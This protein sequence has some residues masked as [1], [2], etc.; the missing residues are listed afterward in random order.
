MGIRQSHYVRAHSHLPTTLNVLTAPEMKDPAFTS[1]SVP[2]A[3]RGEI[4]KTCYRIAGDVKSRR[5]LVCLH[6]GPGVPSDYME[7]F[8]RLTES[9]IP[10]ILYDQFGCGESQ[11]LD[12]E[13]VSRFERINPKNDVWTVKLYVDELDN[14]LDLLGIKDDFDLLG[15]SWGGMLACEYVVDRQ[16]KGLKNLIIA[17]SLAT[18]ADWVKA[19][20][21]I[22]EPG[23]FNFPKVHRNVLKFAEGHEDL[24]DKLTEEE[25]M[26][27][28][29]R[30]ITLDSQEYK[31]ALTSFMIFFDLQVQPW[32][33]PWNRAIAAANRSPVN[34]AMWGTAWTNPTRVLAKW[35]IKEQL[36]KIHVRTLVYNGAYE[37]AQ[38][39]VVAPFVDLIP[40]SKWV[41]F[42][43]S[44]HCPHFEEHDRCMKVV[45]D[46]LLSTD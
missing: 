37:Q 16:P 35:S 1:G 36:H 31:D 25:L 18:M 39:F 14:L 27:L 17:D 34:K 4:F 24:R 12:P 23:V 8:G 3:V 13:D 21:Q 20:R 45:G 38:D 28:Q 19:S 46:F 33:E 9:G 6:G 5:P 29:G 11:P 26:D 41:K 7:P 22:I 43:K 15:H 10:I 30:K 40:G 44:S 42:E 2:F 32:P